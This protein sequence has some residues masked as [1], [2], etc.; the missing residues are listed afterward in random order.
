MFGK[1]FPI[2]KIYHGM[3]KQPHFNSLDF[4][5]K[6]YNALG[7]DYFNMLIAVIHGE[8]ND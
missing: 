5:E 1:R 2:E 4:T 7:E 3:L 8:I 6:S